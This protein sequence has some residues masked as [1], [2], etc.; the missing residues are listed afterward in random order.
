VDEILLAVE[1]YVDAVEGDVEKHHLESEVRQKGCDVEY[2]GRA[3]DFEIE[4]ASSA[5]QLSRGE[6][7]QIHHRRRRHHPS[8]PSH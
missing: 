7:G 1:G 4:E 8:F 2:V 6:M 3:L 5:V